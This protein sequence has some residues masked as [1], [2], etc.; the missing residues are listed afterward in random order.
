MSDLSIQITGID[1]HD[2]PDPHEFVWGEEFYYCG[3]LEDGRHVALCD[4]PG[5][6]W[7]WQLPSEAQALEHM[8]QEL[9][10]SMHSSPEHCD[11]TVEW[12][13]TGAP[14]QQHF[15]GT[16]TDFTKDG[17]VRRDE[18]R[19]FTIVRI[20]DRCEVEEYEDADAALAAALDAAEDLVEFVVAQEDELDAQLIEAF[21]MC[22]ITSARSEMWSETAARRVRDCQYEDGPD[23]TR[24][25]TQMLAERFGMPEHL[26]LAHWEPHLQYAERLG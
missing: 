13:L 22:E 25:P 19:Y 11:I 6:S 26:V 8:T 21:L 2:I 9:V 4:A 7:C 23:T 20:G 15:V 10:D 3:T 1:V 5:G 14:V 18:G 16:R 17:I 24:T 12:P